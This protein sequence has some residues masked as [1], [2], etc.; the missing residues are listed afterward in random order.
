MGFPAFDT[1]NN[2]NGVRV[3]CEQQ[4]GFS[5]TGVD[6]RPIYFMEDLFRGLTSSTLGSCSE[7]ILLTVCYCGDR[8]FDDT[9]SRPTTS[10][11]PFLVLCATSGRLEAPIM[12]Q[13]VN[14]PVGPG[15]RP[16]AQY[17]QSDAALTITML[18][19]KNT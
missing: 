10:A 12:I 1:R 11:I 4:R 17:Q 14:R 9:P 5:R 7:R 8:R 6:V 2:A 18:E 16:K 13:L 19:H 15:P 3:R